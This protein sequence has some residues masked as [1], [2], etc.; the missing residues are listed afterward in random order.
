MVH[1]FPQELLLTLSKNMKTQLDAFIDSCPKSIK[2]TD[3]RVLFHA[4]NLYNAPISVAEISPD[5]IESPVSFYI[6]KV[7]NTAKIFAIIGCKA[8]VIGSVDDSFTNKQFVESFPAFDF[9][10]EEKDGRAYFFPQKDV[11]GKAIAPMSLEKSV[12]VKELAAEEYNLLKKCF[13]SV[14][15]SLRAGDSD[16]LKDGCQM[17]I[18]TVPS[19]NVEEM[20][21]FDKNANSSLTSD[22]IT[23]PFSIGDARSEA[24]QS[25]GAIMTQEEGDIQVCRPITC[26]GNVKICSGGSYDSTENIILNGTFNF[27][28]PLVCSEP[29]SNYT[30]MLIL[31]VSDGVVEL[32]GE[33]VQNVDGN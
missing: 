4:K 20:L 22:N 1:F 21:P 24:V 32:V 13:Y 28:E 15:M 30:G 3:N 12:D 9:K 10:V 33:N 23:I 29:E 17:E 7:K 5:L 18:N 26:S 16:L 11:S 25:G 19:E 2:K 8:M 27:K 14:F 31:N 6:E